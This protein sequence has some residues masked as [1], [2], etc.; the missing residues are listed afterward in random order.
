MFTDLCFIWKNRVKTNHWA[1][2]RNKTVEL[3]CLSF[4]LKWK[5]VSN[6]MMSF[7]GIGETGLLRVQKSTPDWS[8]VFVL[9]LA[10]RKLASRSQLEIMLP[11][12]SL[13]PL[14]PHKV[15]KG[16]HSTSPNFTLPPKIACVCD[17][18]HPSAEEAGLTVWF[19]LGA[20]C[21]AFPCGQGWSPDAIFG[22]QPPPTP[23]PSPVLM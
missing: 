13:T 19:L 3:I 2:V 15:Y 21:F 17:E 10:D 16:F 4:F 23:T 11:S 8:D 18:S 1:D 6:L 12:F 22:G 14:K 7:C 5:S 9:H 20:V